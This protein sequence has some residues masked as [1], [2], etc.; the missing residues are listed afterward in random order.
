MITAIA[1]VGRAD[2]GTPARSPDAEGFVE[3]DGV[4][5]HWESFGHASPTLLLLPTWSIVHSACWK[6]QVPYLSRHFRVIT[7]DGRGNGLS[8]RPRGPVAYMDPEFVD[9]AVAVLDATGTDSAFLVGLSAGGRY[10]FRMAAAHP[11]RVRGIVSIAGRLSFD[12][13]ESPYSKPER[14]FEERESY[15]GFDKVNQHYW[16]SDWRGFVEYYRAEIATKKPR[17]MGWQAEGAA[18][19][20]IG[21]P[22]FRVWNSSGRI[23]SLSAMFDGGPMATGI[24]VPAISG[25]GR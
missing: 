23:S 19:I 7:F 3:R 15:E 17:M 11:G 1:Q 9:D 22:V 6:L 2:T 13:P 12:A 16:L 21:K 20:V 14:F 5:V 25:S 10:A 8:D 18:P 4:R 24:S